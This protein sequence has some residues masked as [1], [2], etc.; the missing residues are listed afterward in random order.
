[1]RWNKQPDNVTTKEII[2]L[3]ERGLTRKQVSEI[4]GWSENH[5]YQTWLNCRPGELT[6]RQKN[7]AALEKYG[8]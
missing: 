6:P 3:F 5:C 2:R 7:T 8:L 1:M 4:T